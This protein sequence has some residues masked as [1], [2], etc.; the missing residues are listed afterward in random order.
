MNFYKSVIEHYGKLL[1]RGIHNGEE[2][3]EKI[4][5]SPTL[6]AITKNKTDHKSLLGQYLK[7]I[8]FDNI[9]KAREFKRS[10]NTSNAPIYGMD[11]YQYQYISDNYPEVIKFSKEHIKIFTL[12]IECSAENGFP[13]VNNP[14]E[15][16][17]AITVK[18]QSNK[19]ILTWGIG[20]Y[21]T[22]RTDVTYIK[23]KSEKILI[24]EFMKFWMKN[25]PDVITGWN[26]KFFDLPYLC[27]RIKLLTDEKVVRKLSPWNLVETE[28]IVVR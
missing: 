23:C 24:M 17:L 28:E 12:D 6:F 18:N 13:E 4:D 3:K 27:N 25:Y 22:D 16:L 26:T 5:Y 10:Y 11:R 21:K 7:P 15:Q 20:D 19:Q 8:K 9:K 14:V 2:F 1:V